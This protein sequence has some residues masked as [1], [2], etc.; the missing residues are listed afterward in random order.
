[1]TSTKN[2]GQCNPPDR[3]LFPGLL[4]DEAAEVTN[5]WNPHVCFL[6]SRV[7]RFIAF[8]LVIV[9]DVIV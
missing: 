5:R 1:M 8:T 3:H 6:R 9:G 7:P 2:S 4:R